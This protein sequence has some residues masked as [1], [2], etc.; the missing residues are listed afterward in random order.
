[1]KTVCSH[2]HK[3]F[4]VSERAL[5]KRAQCKACGK[6]F[7]VRPEGVD[8]VPMQEVGPG[9]TVTPDP[10]R[11]VAS[12]PGRRADADD[13]LAALAQAA[14]SSQH[15]YADRVQQHA[16]EHGSYLS[17]RDHGEHGDTAPGAFAS[18]VMGILGLVFAPIVVGGVLSVLAVVYGNG[19]RRRIRR[20]RGVLE[21]RGQATAGMLLGWAGLLLLALA[22]IGVLV[23]LISRGQVVVKQTTK[24]A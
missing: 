15:D 21:G 17:K 23:W 2:C 9:S 7:V 12:H 1:M 3:L 16:R 13:P 8:D 6:V 5:G 19:A 10:P 22:G 24:P 11:P 14:D 20:S 4:Q 18:L